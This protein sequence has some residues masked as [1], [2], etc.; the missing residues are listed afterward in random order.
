MTMKT[1]PSTKP[2]IL[3]ALGGLLLGAAATAQNAILTLPA[4]TGDDPRSVR[5][6]N[7]LHLA[8][9]N[10]VDG[11][12]HFVNI[13]NPLTPTL[14]TSYN[15]PYG[16][17]WFE[18]EFTPDY[19]G[20]LFTAHRGGGV[21][22]IDTTNPATPVAVQSIP[23]AYHFRGLRYR[24]LG[25]TGCLY[26]NETNNGLGVFNVTGNASLMSLV[27]NN[28]NNNGQNDANGLEVIGNQLYFMGTPPGATSTRL[29][30]GF[31]VSAPL[32]PVQNFA[33]TFT[34]QSTSGHCL[35][36]RHSTQPLMIASRW[37]DG[38]QTINAT[39]PT[40]PVVT[41]VLPGTPNLL[42][43]GATFWPNSPFAIA[44]GQ[45]IF[46]SVRIYW[47][48]LFQVLPNGQVIPINFLFPNLDTHD[49]AI[50]PTT[51][52]IYVVGRDPNTLQGKLWVF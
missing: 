29:F 51:N 1:S 40:S 23:T 38:L 4:G 18:A 33:T 26:Y 35:M 44:Y 39:N 30:R 7:R 48:F 13:V 31:N 37:F 11:W 6:I 25:N 41:P 21:N 10:Q 42:C 3:A 2:A 28:Y 15:P 27:W 9:S 32:A 5:V 36:R 14:T 16:D 22:M 43:W 34:N 46:G 45:F 50:D 19:G 20:R 49:I 52:R 47:W 8:I 17:Q 12:Q 24:N